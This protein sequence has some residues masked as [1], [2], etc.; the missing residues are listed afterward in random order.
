VARFVHMPKVNILSGPGA[1]GK[2]LTL[3]ERTTKRRAYEDVVDQIERAILTGEMRETDRLPSE[4]ELIGQF[5]V[6]RATI[7]EA[8]RVLQSRGFIDVRH[9]DPSGAVIRANPGASVAALLNSLFRA[10][11]LTLADVIQF[12]ILVESAAAALAA[13]SSAKL[14]AAIRKAYS[15]MKKTK[16]WD[17]QVKA[18]V[19]FHRRVAEASKNPLFVL[20][21]EALHQFQPVATWL[22][23]RTL[24]AARAQTLEV[25]GMILDAIEAGNAAKAAELSRFHLRRSYQPI[26]SKPARDRLALGEDQI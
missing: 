10:D 26:L 19:L 12:R 20:V 6:S 9:G 3:F 4:R 24:D 15:D 16:T 14:I 17:E 21:V 18:D 1:D 25:H 2:E 23:K 11:R 8:L 22:S 13:K 7:R 5:G